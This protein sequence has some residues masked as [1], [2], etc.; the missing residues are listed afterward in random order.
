MPKDKGGLGLRNLR[1]WNNIVALK[2]I[3]SLFFRAGSLWVGWIRRKYLL[4]SSFW[5]VS[6]KPTQSWAFRKLLKLRQWAASF[7]H[8]I[9]GNGHKTK[10]W[11]DP[12]TKH[13]PLLQFL[14]TRGPSQLAI[15]LQ[16]TLVEAYSNGAWAM[17]APRSE[18]A[19]QLAITLTS[20]QLSSAHDELKWNAGEI[21]LSSFVSKQIWSL[22]FWET[23]SVTWD[24]TIWFK[25]HV[26]KHAFL[27]WELMLDR[28]PTRTDVF[29]V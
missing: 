27:S 23:Q 24:K 18:A 29:A 4:R 16:A 12:W 26:P 15:P 11:F 14:S 20:V 17:D 21:T 2:L 6:V 9:V 8:V 1:R 5:S 13:G 3:W 28:C 19:L 22:E 10:F 25:S 7:F